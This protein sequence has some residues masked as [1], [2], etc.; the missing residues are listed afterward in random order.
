MLTEDQIQRAATQFPTPFYLYHEQGIRETTRQLYAAFAWAPQFMNFFAVKATPNPTILAILAEE[1]CGMDCSSLA[2][3]MLSERVGVSGQRIMFSSNNTPIE[4]FRFA[5][6]RDALINLDDPGHLRF[7]IQ[8]VGLPKNLSL[9]YNPGPLRQGNA[10]I[11]Q[12]QEAKFGMT[13]EQMVQC[14]T[15][16]QE[17]GIQHFG[18]HTMLASNELNADYFIATAHMLFEL[19]L[20]VWAETGIRMEF[21]NLGGGI[22]IPYRPDQQ[23]VDLNYLSAGVRAAY[24]QLIMPSVLHPLKMFME[25]GRVLTGPHGILVTQ[26]RHIKE[27]YKHFVGVDATMADLMRPGMY[28]AYHHISVPGKQGQPFSQLYD[29]TGSLCENNDKFAIDRQL[30]VLAPGDLLVIH[31]AGAHGRAMGFNY[32]GKLRSAEVLLQKNGALRLIRRAETLDDDF[33]TLVF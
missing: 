5:L 14:Y 8:H 29:I 13:A 10:I 9:R 25:C 18:L 7:I 24:E 32:N 12:P 16:A 19:A 2:E 6:E 22:G 11:G 3:L 27:T 17:L 28:G 1:G 23:A 20:R 33:A 4:E 15:D 31:D 21:V 30:P 26:V